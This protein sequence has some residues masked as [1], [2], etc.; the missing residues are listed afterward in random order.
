M[1]NCTWYIPEVSQPLQS[2][3]VSVNA[4]KVD[5]DKIPARA[6]GAFGNVGYE[7]HAI[8]TGNDG[9]GK[10]RWPE[11]RWRISRRRAVQWGKGVHQ[12]KG[13]KG[14]GVRGVDQEIGLCDT[15]RVG[16]VV[17]GRQV[18]EPDLV[19]L[20]N[21]KMTFQGVGQWGVAVIQ[22]A[23]VRAVDGVTG[24]DAGG[25]GR[26]KV[27]RV[28]QRFG[29]RAVHGDNLI[30]TSGVS[31]GAEGTADLEGELSNAWKLSVALNL[32]T[33]EDK[34]ADRK[35]GSGAAQVNA[36]AVSLAAVFDH[37]GGNLLSKVDVS[38]GGFDIFED[39]GAGV[40]Q[41]AKGG[42]GQIQG[43]VEGKLEF[44][45]HSGYAAD[46]VGAVD[47]AAVPGVVGDHGGFDPNKVSAAISA[48]DGDSLVQIA[49]EAF[50][51][52]S[53]VVAARDSMVADTENS[54]GFFK[55]TT[56]GTASVNH[57]EAAHANFQK[58][59]LKEKAGEFVGVD[60][61]NWNADNELGET[62]HG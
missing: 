33:D 11:S 30:T 34:V 2:T 38:G 22:V 6:R 15:C 1:K 54:T 50:N 26:E 32:D 7:E 53:F 3:S 56:E 9:G 46:N 24:K 14:A 42:C 17:G 61:G 19:V 4:W 23:E 51:A 59:F 41:R 16:Q 58:Y 27:G 40:G 18:G 29:I 35:G 37:K 44:T 25:S 36:I 47:Q 8:G 20:L 21:V 10:G 55:D 60:V 5:T 45:A 39:R 62:A 31:N 49:E 12:S 52:D 13:G 57:D 43:K 48:G 28:R